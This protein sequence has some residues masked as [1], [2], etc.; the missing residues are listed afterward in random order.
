MTQRRKFI[1]AVSGLLITPWIGGRAIAI[2][3]AADP[4]RAARPT[5]GAAAPTIRVVGIGGAGRAV[6]EHFRR[7]R[8]PGIDRTV[9]IGTSTESRHL[10][11]PLNSGIDGDLSDTDSATIQDAVR[12]ANL[13]FLVA[14][15]GGETGTRVAPLVADAARVEGAEVVA[16]LITPFAFEGKRRG[17]A[18]RAVRV[19]ARSANRTIRFSNEEHSQQVGPDVS[20]AT[21]FGQINEEIALRLREVISESASVA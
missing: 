1:I 11:V 13:V 18:E 6:V 9:S 10:D 20:V 5:S 8:I 12:G 15:L 19:M 16:L 4:A 21:F 7:E 2:R 14:G 17:V 3:S